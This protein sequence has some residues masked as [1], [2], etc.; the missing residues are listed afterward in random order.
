M[1]VL[2]WD[3][4][5]C[6]TFMSND[7][8]SEARLESPMY[9]ADTASEL[10]DTA[11]FLNVISPFELSDKSW[12]IFS[13]A[14]AFS[15]R[16][17]AYFWAA[18]DKSKLVYRGLAVNLYNLAVCVF[19]LGSCMGIILGIHPVSVLGQ[20]VAIYTTDHNSHLLVCIINLYYICSGQ[21]C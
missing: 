4:A 3:A 16:S 21:H 12:V 17:I 1:P 2:I 18:L 20:V 10:L 11:D 7:S 8:S 5:S 19:K 9:C 13:R 6:F 14:R 15:L